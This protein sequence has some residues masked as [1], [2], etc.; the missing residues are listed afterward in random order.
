MKCPQCILP[1]T[2]TGSC[3]WHSPR[4]KAKCS[5]G[6]RDV[7]LDVA[8]ASAAEELARVR[9]RVV[10]LTRLTRHYGLSAWCAEGGHRACIETDCACRCH[11][12]LLARAEEERRS[13][14]KPLTPLTLRERTTLRRVA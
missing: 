2:E 5:F 1:A 9:G 11:A 6:G 10:V 12:P 3:F 8:R 7:P 14:Q 13:Y 4:E